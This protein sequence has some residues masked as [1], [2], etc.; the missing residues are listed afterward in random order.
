MFV[1]DPELRAEVARLW[2]LGLSAP[3]PAGV[4]GPGPTRMSF[5]S[6]QWARIGD[7]LAHLMRHMHEVPLLLIP[8]LR[9][10]SRAELDSTQG[11]A[12]GWGSVVPALWSFMLAARE[13]GLGTA[14]TT[15][16]L[17]HE[18]EISALLGIPYDTVV[19]VALTP[20]AHTLGTDF[21]PGPRTDPRQL[22][23]WNS[24]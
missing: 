24:W 18:R 23:H 1:E 7:S 13:R 20:V 22:V 10:S 6:D 19:Q 12:N 8:C 21:R 15:G 17:A 2:R 14:W 11:Q 16:N 9:V 4:S 5:E 3:P